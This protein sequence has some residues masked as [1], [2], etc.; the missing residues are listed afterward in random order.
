M[1]LIELTH[2]KQAIVEDHW[3]EYL[4]QFKWRAYH[5]RSNGAWYAVRN[6]VLPSGKQT[7]QLMHRVIMGNPAG[8]EVDHRNRDGLCNLEANLRLTV[9][10]NQQ[11]VGLRKDNKSGFKG[12]SRRRDI[13]KWQAHIQCNDK[14]LHLG[15]FSTAVEAAAIYNWAAKK[16]H[17]AFAYQNDLSQI[18]DAALTQAA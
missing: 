8:L 3:F 14:R 5:R 6:V 10:Q 15:H 16:L 18:S 13:D 17:G 1:K 4:N 11:N 12:V 9:S 2:D 7:A